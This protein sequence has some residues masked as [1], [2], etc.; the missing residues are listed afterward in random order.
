MSKDTG[1]A[2]GCKTCGGTGRICA[3]NSAFPAD[4]YSRLNCG[5]CAGTGRS[6]YLPNPEYAA[7]QLKRRTS[8]HAKD[9]PQ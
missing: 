2:G 7:H 1:G 8:E 4:G 9:N 3:D 6:G 5:I